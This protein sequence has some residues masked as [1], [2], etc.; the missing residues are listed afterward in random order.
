MNG[1]VAITEDSAGA[2]ESVVAAT[3][4]RRSDLRS[5][6]A[7]GA[8]FGVVFGAVYAAAWIGPG[9]TTPLC[10]LWF[11]TLGHG[12]HLVM[13]EC[14]HK[15]AFR[16]PARNERLACWLVAPLYFTD[17][18]AL[19]NRHWRHHRTVGTAADP[20][21]SYRIDIRGGRFL[22]LVGETLAVV[23]ALRKASHQVGGHSQASP[24][25]TRRSALAIAIVQPIFALSIVL[26]ARLGHPGDWAGTWW[27]AAVAYGVVYG[28]GIASLTVLTATLRAIAEHRPAGI[29]PVVRGDAA[30]R[31]FSRSA[32]DRW[33]FGTYGFAEHATHHRYPAVPSYALPE[34]TRRLAANDRTLV[35]V[36]THFA[37]LVRQ[38]SG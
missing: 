5:A 11:G 18:D 15:L 13:H 1:A 33:V 32:I 27:A 37:V 26:A 17:F 24:E 14:L 7:I 16:E 38:V 35:P 2:D 23:G 10:L 30:F 21:Y 12:F 25:S 3:V 22:R 31:N 29:D 6:A 36:G 20:K 4:Q 28:Y 8:H 9:W 19:R 34:L